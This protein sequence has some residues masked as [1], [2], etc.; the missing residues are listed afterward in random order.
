MNLKSILKLFSF[1]N[2][3][4]SLKS[5]DKGTGY[6]NKV[7]QDFGDSI[8]LMIKELGSDIEKSKKNQKQRESINKANLEKIWDKKYD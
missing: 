6:F 7:M 5:F 8:E 1:E 3:D 4:K 2:I